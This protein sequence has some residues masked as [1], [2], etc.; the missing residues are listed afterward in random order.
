[1]IHNKPYFWQIRAFDEHNFQSAWTTGGL[2]RFTGT[3]P[4]T[5][6][7]LVPSDSTEI[8][9]NGELSWSQCIDNDPGPLDTLRYVV[10][11][12][13]DAALSNIVSMDTIIV[14][15]SVV[16]KNTNGINVLNDDS[17]YYWTVKSMD[18]HGTSS[19]TP[20]YGAFYFNRSNSVP[21]APDSLS[22]VRL[23]YRRPFQALRWV[24]SDPDLEDTLVYRVELSTDT[25]F[26]VP[27]RVI[28]DWN[29]TYLTIDTFSNYKEILEHDTVYYWR[30]RATDKEGQISSWS[31]YGSFTYDEKDDLATA[32]VI[33]S[34]TYNEYVVGASSISWQNSSDPDDSLI[35]YHIDVST[36]STF[37]SVG[38]Y[39]DSI[40]EDT[41]GSTSVKFSQLSGYNNIVQN[42]KYYLRIYPQSLVDTTW[43]PGNTSET[44]RVMLGN[45]KIFDTT[46]LSQITVI[47]PIA[48][49]SLTNVAVSVDSMVSIVFPDSV[50]S[51]QA[52]VKITTVPIY[53]TIIPPD[54]A[55]YNTS[56][57]TIQR[58]KS[59]VIDAN[60]YAEGDRRIYYIKER[61]YIIDL[62][63]AN[64]PDSTA[65]LLDSVFLQIEYHDT[66]N[67]DM[68]DG[69]ERIPVSALNLFRLNESSFRWEEVTNSSSIDVTEEGADILR[70][71]GIGKNEKAVSA[72][73]NHFSVY[74][75][76]AKR[77]LPDPF[78]DFKVYPSP[79]K[80]IGN[81]T[82]TISYRLTQNAE[83]DIR[84]YSRTGGLVWEKKYES[85]EEPGGVGSP[86]SPA[87]LISWDGRNKTGRRVGNGA[88]IVKVVVKPDNGKL[89]TK[90]QLL[91][92][93]K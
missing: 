78:G 90:K 32:P 83:V 77:D 34:P 93:V 27:L 29:E 87:K 58:L 25:L 67:N 79:F 10:T 44:W 20:V 68:V 39:L 45:E 42:T 7:N 60:K 89:V 26:T 4:T 53:G 19:P 74:T 43:I 88:Y 2:F 14:D 38:A 54:T 56:D 3:A 15:T 46:G 36:D 71:R 52:L 24:G 75:I 47:D 50:V 85:G 23:T 81:N 6:V 31:E 17:Y 91:G 22:P 5:P 8:T 28:N 92:V 16:L 66:N 13:S 12:F 64:N 37:S 70:K 1:M 41:S 63:D 69:D 65:S 51:K 84:I 73:T 30:V 48:T 61:A 40:V 33:I 62:L 35:V 57:V 21:N 9:V 59:I 49:G 80:A 55:Q 18:V 11:L 82:A 86:G 72:V 76:L